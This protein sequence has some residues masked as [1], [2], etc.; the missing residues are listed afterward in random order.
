MEPWDKSTTFKL[1]GTIH[2][3]SSPTTCSS[4][5]QTPFV[6]F[7]HLLP[8]LCGPSPSSAVPVLVPG[9]SASK[10]PTSSNP[11][12]VQTHRKTK[13]NMDGT[14]TL[15]P[16][17]YHPGKQ[18]AFSTKQTLLSL[19]SAECTIRGIGQKSSHWKAL[20]IAGDDIEQIEAAWATFL[21]LCCG[22]DI[23]YLDITQQATSGR[24]AGPQ[25]PLTAE[26]PQ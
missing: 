14:S 1:Y 3:K 23:Y 12:T 24:P 2:T 16:I 21:P 6:F 17:L 8:T 4:S 10:A 20:L 5:S 19:L 7:V 22:L 9:P 15:A 25:Q 13:Q 26:P 11:S 18:A